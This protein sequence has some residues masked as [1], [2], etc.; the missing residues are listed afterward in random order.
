MPVATIASGTLS[1]CQALTVAHGEQQTNMMLRLCRSVGFS[2]AADLATASF[3]AIDAQRVLFVLVHYEMGDEA[4]QKLVTTLRRS[5]AID[6]GFAPII[7]FVPDIAYEEVLRYIEMGFDDVVSL[8]EKSDILHSRLENQLNAEHVY[9][10]T[11]SYIGPDRRRMEL[12][13]TTHP[14]R[15]GESEYTRLLIRRVPGHGIQIVSRQ[16]FIRG[17]GLESVAKRASAK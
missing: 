14:E 11:A 4:K 1:R 7:L 8:P 10:E 3:D 13:G 17:R 12:P 15:R 5:E 9:V 16:H 2:Q 6:I